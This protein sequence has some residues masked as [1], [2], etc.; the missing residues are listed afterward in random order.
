[1]IPS[2][3]DAFFLV[4]SKSI[5]HNIFSRR[6]PSEHTVNRDTHDTSF[7][8]F[9]SQVDVVLHQPHAGVAGPALLVVVAHDVLVVGIRMAPSGTAGSDPW[10]RPL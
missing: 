3:V 10:P 8:K 9:H 5:H 1:M 7:R 2:L 6:G 4:I